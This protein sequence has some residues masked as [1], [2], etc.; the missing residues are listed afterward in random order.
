M[1]VLSLLQNV[2]QVKEDYA[3]LRRDLNEVQELQRQVQTTVRFRAMQVQQRYQALR[4]RIISKA[5][6]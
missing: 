6:K 2:T 1:S 4:D 5:N 3:N